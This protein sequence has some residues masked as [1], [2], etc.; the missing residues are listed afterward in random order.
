GLWTGVMTRMIAG[1]ERDQ[2]TSGSLETF[3]PLLRNWGKQ[4]QGMNRK[5]L[6]TLLLTLESTPALVARAATRLSAE[7]TRRRTADGAFSLIENV[8]HLADLE[9]EGY[10]VRLRRILAEDDPFLSDFDGDRIARER[11]YQSR[12]LAK[13]LALFATA[14]EQNLETLRSLSP[15]AWRRTGKQEGVGRVTLGDVARMMAEHDRSHTRDITDLIAQFRGHSDSRRR[16][17][18]VMA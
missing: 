10:A 5:E 6:E 12:D 15:S 1:S 11:N 14:R 13:G 9:Q 3:S 4:E 2:K 8:W 16:P 7:E 18:S 17:T